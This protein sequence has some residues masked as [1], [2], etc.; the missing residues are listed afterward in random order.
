MV[1]EPTWK[2]VLKFIAILVLLFIIQ[3]GDFFAKL[4]RFYLEIWEKDILRFLVQKL[5]KPF[6]K[7]HYCDDKE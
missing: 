7:A 4:A 5:A 6:V 1:K 2:L 3:L